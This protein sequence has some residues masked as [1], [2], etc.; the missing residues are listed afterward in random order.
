[1]YNINNSFY[2]LMLWHSQFSKNVKFSQ[3]RIIAILGTFIGRKDM[4]L[5]TVKISNYR[6]LNNV[7]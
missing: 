1:M 3:Q 6:L 7:H 2:I 4:K 5:K